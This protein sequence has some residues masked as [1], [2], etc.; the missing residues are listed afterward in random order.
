M[1]IIQQCKVE[2]LIALLEA[3][4]HTQINEFIVPQNEEIAP[5]FL[6]ELAIDKL[7]Q[8]TVN[9]FWWSPRL[10]VVR[11]EIVGTIGFKNP[12]KLDYSVEIGYG[13]IPSKQRQGFATE[14]VKL[15][16][17]EAFSMNEIQT[18][19]AH[20]TPTN[21]SSQRVLEKNGFNKKKNKIDLED[22]EVWEWQRKR[23][24]NM[25]TA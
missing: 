2:H 12:P 22:V 9:A 24:D 18:V 17:E 20:T 6:L 11:N 16:L 25:Q 3:G 1:V 23:A 8:D 4:N 7:K 13:V 19:I 15:L 14:A 21:K 5:K 10:I